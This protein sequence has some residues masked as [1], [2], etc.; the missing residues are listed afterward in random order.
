MSSERFEWR[1]NELFDNGNGRTIGI[2][3]Q[4]GAIEFDMMGREIILLMLNDWADREREKLWRAKEDERQQSYRK[5]E[6]LRCEALLKE[7]EALLE[8]LRDA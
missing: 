3:T 7:S 8:K 2:A 5:Q 6:L 4:R 1:G